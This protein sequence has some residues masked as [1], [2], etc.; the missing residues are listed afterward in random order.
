MWERRETD[1]LNAILISS[2]YLL[3]W[4]SIRVILVIITNVENGLAFNW[5]YYMIECISKGWRGN[6]NIKE[7]HD[8]VVLGN[9]DR[10]LRC[11]SLSSSLMFLCRAIQCAE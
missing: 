4:N 8:T 9:N 1:Q 2:L 3:S 7:T 6:T 5:F 11:S 10:Y